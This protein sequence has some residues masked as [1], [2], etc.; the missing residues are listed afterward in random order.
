MAENERCE[1]CER[2][3]MPLYLEPYREHSLCYQCLMAW[4]RLDMIVQTIFQ[5]DA[6]WQEFLDPRPSWFRDRIVEL[7]KSIVDEVAPSTAGGRQYVR[8]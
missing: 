8:H 5:R 1:G 2:Y 3:M 4:R 7:E 6:T